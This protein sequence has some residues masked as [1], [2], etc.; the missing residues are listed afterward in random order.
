[1]DGQRVCLEETRESDP[2]G[3]TGGVHRGTWWWPGLKLC[4]IPAIHYNYFMDISLHFL[5][6]TEPEA[7]PAEASDDESFFAS[8]DAAATNAPY[9]PS[10]VWQWLGMRDIIDPA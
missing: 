4:V 9:S 2:Y 5:S 7:A 1:M 8:M 6:A 10:T 3:W